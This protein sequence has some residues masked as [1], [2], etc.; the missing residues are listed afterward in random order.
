MAD[1]DRV[2]SSAAVVIFAGPLGAGKTEIAISYALAA[3]RAGRDAR[4]MD[5]D[6][7]TPYF[8]VGDCR[9]LLEQMGL[10]VIAAEG[11]LA[12]FENPSL[13]PEIGGAL[14]DRGAHLI[15]D[16][17]GDPEG[18]R[19]LG[20]YTPQITARGYDLWLVVN[21]YRAGSST[22]AIESQR[23]AIEDGTGLRASGL[24]ANPH[25]GPLTQ[26]VHV[27]RGLKVVREA[28]D[29]MGLRIAFLA[30][31][32]RLAA[33]LTAVELPVLPLRLF[34]RLPWEAA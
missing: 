23:W 1:T 10:R 32:E 17:G 30:A 26:A 4:L 9:E 33:D 20:V 7:V 13:S 8:R 11:A 28:G 19:L 14:A 5:F 16:V 12:S 15:L 18:A 25:L 2:L 27:E 29:R 21:P 22:E 34:L 3:H 6:I 31:A 24:V